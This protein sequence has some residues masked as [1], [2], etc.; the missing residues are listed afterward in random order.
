MKLL[1][2]AMMFYALAVLAAAIGFSAQTRGG[3]RVMR[4]VF[5]L[6]LAT[7]CVLIVTAG[8]LARHTL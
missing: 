2:I 7:A 1:Q 6:T 4:I 8:A 3:G 5:A